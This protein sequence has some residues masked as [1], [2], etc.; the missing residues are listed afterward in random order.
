MGLSDHQWTSLQK[1]GSALIFLV[2]NGSGV[3]LAQFLENGH[4]PGA[5]GQPY[6]VKSSRKYECLAFV[7]TGVFTDS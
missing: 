7:N 1:V 4:S 6:F 3:P 2:K 5:S